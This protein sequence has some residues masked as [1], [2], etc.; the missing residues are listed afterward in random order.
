MAKKSPGKSAPAMRQGVVKKTTRAARKTTETA[1]KRTIIPAEPTKGRAKASARRKPTASGF[2]GQ[3][4]EGMKAPAFRLTREDGSRISLGDFNGRQ[5]VIYFYPRADTPGCTREAIDFNRLRAE[6]AKV[7]TGVIG[8]SADPPKAQDAFRKKYELAIPLVSDETRGTIE[9]Y[10]AWGEKSMYGRTF[11]GIL[12]TTVLIGAD[13]RIA[14][15]WRHVK[16]DG[17]ADAVLAAA[18]SLKD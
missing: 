3:L 12:R 9:A 10:D 18:R 16:V 8:I 6:F 14:R 5:L 13:G 7:N 2:P 15:I 4:A 11:E 17:H 1:D